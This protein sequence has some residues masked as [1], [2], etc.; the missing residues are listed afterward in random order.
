MISVYLMR[1][2]P[3]PPGVELGG[4]SYCCDFGKHLVKYKDKAL[5][6]PEFLFMKTIQEVEL[7]QWL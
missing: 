4:H 3:G 7:G 6:L 5:I 1:L 2:V